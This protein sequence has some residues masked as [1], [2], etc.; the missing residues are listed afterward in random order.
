M[1]DIRKSNYEWYEKIELLMIWENRIMND[2]RKSNYEWYENIKLWMIWDDGVDPTDGCSQNSKFKIWP[3]PRPNSEFWIL[4]GKGDATTGSDPTRIGARKIQNSKIGCLRGQFLNFYFCKEKVDATTG[5]DPTRIGARKI[6]NSEF[7]RLR[8]QILNFEF[9]KE[10]GDATT[11]TDPT[12]P[13]GTNIS[14]I[15]GYPW[16]PPTLKI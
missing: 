15:E 11:G 14:K 1:N 9:C 12:R 3:P 8:G 2:M 13:K 6:Q 10:K 4:Q 16:G 7:G 5:T